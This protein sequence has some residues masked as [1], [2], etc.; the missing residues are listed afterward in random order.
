[1]SGHKYFITLIDDYSRFG[2]V[3][4]I[5]EKFDSLEAFKVFKEKVELQ[6]GK[7]IKVV[8][9]DRGLHSYG[10][11]DEKGCN[12]GPFAKYIQEC[13]IEAHFTMSSTPQQNGI[14]ERKNRTLLDI[15]RCMPI[16]SP[17]PEFLWGKAL[18]VVAY[19]L[20]QV[21]SKSVPKTSYELWSQKKPNLRDFHV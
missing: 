1:M 20:N 21:P 8:Y 3:E 7:K 4:L 13:G 18:K 15:V 9:S 5:R 10:R 14:A 12:P 19:I 6:Q 17:L 11:Y 2:F 16:N